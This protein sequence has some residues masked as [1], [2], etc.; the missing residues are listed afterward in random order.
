M[1]KILTLLL[2]VL[3]L[4]ASAQKADYAKLLERYNTF[5]TSLTFDDHRQLYYG[6]VSQPGYSAK[7]ELKQ[8]EI[9]AAITKRDFANVILLCDE[10]LKTYPISLT[11]NYAKGL[12]LASVNNNDS[13]YGKYLNRYATLL[14][15]IAAS[16]DGKTA[17]TAFKTIFIADEIE[18]IY[19]YFGIQK[20]L[21]QKA[22][23]VYD[24]FE[25]VPSEKWPDKKIYFDVS[26]VLKKEVVK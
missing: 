1:K 16:G 14:R 19:R 26:E 4:S 24:V 5:D 21:A 18:M 3:A 22:E 6:F 11:A 10:V 15:V 8:K 23:G 13:M 20:H 2:I 9:N 7:P 25:V 12:A 17:K